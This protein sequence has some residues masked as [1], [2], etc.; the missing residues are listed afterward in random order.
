MF[1]NAT[2]YINA[3]ITVSLSNAEERLD[4]FDLYNPSTSHGGSLKVVNIGFHHPEMGFSISQNKE[5]YWRRKNMSDL[6]FKSAIVVRSP[7]F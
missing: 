1:R 4:I 5:K 7:I 3:D 6:I 2:I